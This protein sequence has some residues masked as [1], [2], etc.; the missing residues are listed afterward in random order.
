MSQ[1][2]AFMAAEE[3]RQKWPAKRKLELNWIICIIRKMP[4]FEFSEFCRKCRSSFAPWRAEVETK[5][6]AIMLE[7]GQEFNKVV[8]GTDAPYVFTDDGWLFKYWS[9]LFLHTHREGGGAWHL[10]DTR[11][12]I[13]F[14]HIGSRTAQDAMRMGDMCQYHRIPWSE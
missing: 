8:F 11:Y 1:S 12:F 7:T 3:R 10:P 5:L 4:K 6:G 9:F 13:D 2:S 14:L